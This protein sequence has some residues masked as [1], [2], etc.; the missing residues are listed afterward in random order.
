MIGR[1]YDRL[2][3]LR[4]QSTITSN[5]EA[6]PL[7][8]P[9]SQKKDG[10]RIARKSRCS[11]QSIIPSLPVIENWLR[12]AKRGAAVLKD[13]KQRRSTSSSYTAQGGNSARLNLSKA[14]FELTRIQGRCCN[15]RWNGR[16]HCQAGHPGLPQYL[17]W[18]GKAKSRLD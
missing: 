1:T 2:G 7:T 5:K 13:S 18:L 3:G 14:M 15:V 4:N 16:V 11:T 12:N 8:W 10:A 6:D 9:W 17:L